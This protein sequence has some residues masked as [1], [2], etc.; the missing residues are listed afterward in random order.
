MVNTYAAQSGGYRF[1]SLRGFGFSL[2]G[3]HYEVGFCGKYS[4]FGAIFIASHA[5]SS[6][7]PVFL[8]FIIVRLHFHFVNLVGMNNDLHAFLRGQK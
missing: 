7:A 3:A 1:E 8:L 5:Q 6:F 2:K 4:Q